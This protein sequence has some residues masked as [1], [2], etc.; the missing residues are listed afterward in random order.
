MPAFS[1]LFLCLN[2]ALLALDIAN[3]SEEMSGFIDM[4]QSRPG[5]TEGSGMFYWFFPAVNRK[6]EEAPLLMWLQGG[7]GSFDFLHCTFLCD[8]VMIFV[9]I[10]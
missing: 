1:S 2:V 8:V 6:P 4:S 5:H 9:M 3:A 7:P 10:F